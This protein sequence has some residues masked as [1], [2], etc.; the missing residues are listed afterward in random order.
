M[1]FA[2]LPLLLVVMLLCFY[3][4]KLNMC[5]IY[6]YLFF[7][8]LILFN[9]FFWDM[10]F[11]PQWYFFTC[12]IIVGYFLNKI[13]P[14]GI[15]SVLL[16]IVIFSFFAYNIFSGKNLNVDVFKYN[17][18]NFIS[19]ILITLSMYVYLCDIKN[20]NVKNIIFILSFVICCFS[21]GRSGIFVSLMILFIYQFEARNFKV[22]ILTVMLTLLI[23]LFFWEDVSV[24]FQIALDRFEN[25]GLVDSH[26]S[27]VLKCYYER[28]NVGNLFL[29]LNAY[30][31]SVCGALAIGEYS[32]HNS[33]VYLTTN[34][35]FISLIIF[36]PI[37]FGMMK[38]ETR[39]VSLLI[40][41]FVIRSLT[42]NMLYYTFFDIIYW[43]FYF[44]VYDCYKNTIRR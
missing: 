39:F 7:S 43:C 40:S 38:K 44:R 28:L 34:S 6:T 5:F 1:I 9:H 33:L 24:Y 31:N 32:P 14:G 8:V 30:G 19:I 4:S 42:D 15:L 16:F 11:Y 2:A 27:D 20:K 29:G 21:F 3:S 41:L 12:S 22:T 35:G 37:F 23:L 36:L 18:R 25:Y 13:K 17:S 26:R 10:K